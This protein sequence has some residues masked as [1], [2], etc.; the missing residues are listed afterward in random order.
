MVIHL[1]LLGLYMAGGAVAKG[2]AGAV[3][4][5]IAAN[6]EKKAK[7]RRTI[8]EA[9]AVPPGYA[10]QPAL[11]GNY[12]LMT[13]P[14]DPQNDEIL[15]ATFRF[16]PC[17]WTGGQSLPSVPRRLSRHWPCNQLSDNIA[18]RLEQETPSR[19]R[20]PRQRRHVVSR[21]V[22]PKGRTSGRLK[23]PTEDAYSPFSL[24]GIVRLV[25]VFGARLARPARKAR[26][27]KGHEACWRRRP[28]PP[29]TTTAKLVGDGQAGQ[30]AGREGI[31]QRISR[32]G[33]P[34]MC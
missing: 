12:P 13:D 34:N 24:L 4:S 28:P 26:R 27:R 2:V 1:V 15:I 17:E 14:D 9:T 8:E 6:K 25:R 33:G 18:V 30:R 3:K 20:I 11:L 16:A 32:A 21:K 7:E 23:S 31:T 19:R 5:E 29:M 22:S 10:P